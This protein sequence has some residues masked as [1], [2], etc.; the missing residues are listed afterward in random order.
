MGWEALEVKVPIEQLVPDLQP[1]APHILAVLSHGRF[2]PRCSI[3]GTGRSLAELV[4]LPA[5][6]A[7]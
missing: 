3:G 7:F 1:S 5:S 2:W 4:C 6:A